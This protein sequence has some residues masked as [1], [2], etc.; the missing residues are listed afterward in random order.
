MPDTRAQICETAV[1]EYE[2]EAPRINRKLGKGACMIRT[3]LSPA[4]NLGTEEQVMVALIFPFM[5]VT[6]YPFLRH[7]LCVFTL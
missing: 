5:A 3:D 2:R 4:E 6:R 1:T 7:R